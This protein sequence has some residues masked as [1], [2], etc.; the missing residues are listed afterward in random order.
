MINKPKL[1][2]DTN[3][4]ID[5]LLDE[6]E[7]SKQ[8]ME[9]FESIK[10]T[11]LFSQ[12]TIGELVYVSKIMSKKAIRDSMETRMKFL[13][14]IMYIF[15]HSKS[16]NTVDTDEKINLKCND[17]RDDMFLECA[18]FGKADYLVTDDI[19]SGLHSIDLE[20]ITILTS[21]QFIKL[22]QEQHKE[23]HT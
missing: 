7:S 14:Y 10:I 20:G 5:G 6:K 9:L 21:E 22:Y 8:I 15:Y 12:D 13:N 18:Y 3:V 1:V 11:L 16:V 2:V 17:D 4:F 19:K 23:I